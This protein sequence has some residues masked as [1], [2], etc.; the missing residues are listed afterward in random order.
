[1]KMPNSSLRIALA[2]AALAAFPLTLSAQTSWTWTGNLTG[3]WG[4]T[5]NWSPAS[6][7]A[8]ANTTNITFNATTSNPN[9]FLG[10]DN[11]TVSS[12]TFTSG[13]TGNMSVSLNDNSSGTRNLTLSA[14]TGNAS[15]NVNSGATGNLTIG[16]VVG[17][18]TGNIIL[19]SN[20]DIV[21]NGSG[22]L[23]FNRPTTGG[24]FSITKSGTGTWQ[25]NNNLNNLTAI[26]INGGTMI[27]NTF[28]TGDLGT[29]ASV[30][31]AG[32]TL[33]IGASTG[34]DKNY[35]NNPAFNVTA[36]STLA[37]NNVNSSSY[38]ATISGAGAFAI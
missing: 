5:A 23:L 7:P 35:N 10:T 28:G 16:L 19:G 20:L 36:A 6:V 2:T 11:R 15:I 14:N 9:T 4:S 32:G 13:V 37:Y 27:A 8:A 25:T 24:N 21:H 38:N 22:L 3:G 31:L 29:T 17:N 34:T 30:N 12:L 1:M 33:Q 26:N 18:G